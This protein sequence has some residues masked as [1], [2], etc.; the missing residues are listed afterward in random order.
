M[1]KKIGVENQEIEVPK[2]VVEEKPIE[3]SFSQAK[4]LMKEAKRKEKGPYQ[5]SVKQKA[6]LQKLLEANKARR[7][8]K[9]KQT[10]E[11][12]EAKQEEAKKVV[13]EKKASTVKVKVMPKKVRKPKQVVVEEST[14]DDTEDDSE[15]EVVVMKKKKPP[16]KKEVE[17][18]IAMVNKIDSV[19]SR[20]DPNEQ[21]RKLVRGL[22]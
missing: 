15:P 19:L 14:D 17:K 5:M 9:K 22:F 21:L 8:G 18:K 1:S 4:K 12:I 7:E 13:E 16:V 20:R 3:V 10:E 11:K 2:E 6:N